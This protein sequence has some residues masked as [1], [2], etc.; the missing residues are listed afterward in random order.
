MLQIITPFNNEELYIKDFLDSIVEG[1]KY[2][3]NFKLFL[4]NDF[5]ED[6]SF[7]IAKSY[8]DEH[9]NIKLINNIIKGK[10][11]AINLGLKNVGESTHLKFCDAD[12]VLTSSFFKSIDSILQYDISVHNL[13]IT[14]VNLNVISPLKVNKNIFLNF[15]YVIENGI[16]IPKA[17]W[18][19]KT[20]F[21]KNN[22]IPDEILFEDFWFTFILKKTNK[23]IFYFNNESFYLYR[24]NNNQTFG[25]VNNNSNEIV[26]WRSKRLIKC[27]NGL[28]NLNLY[29]RKK[30][31]HI[32]LY[33]ELRIKFNL[34]SFL[35][36]L[37][38]NF[39]LAIKYFVYFIFGN[40]IF[41]LKNIIWKLK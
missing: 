25:G 28:I 26:S 34:R 41:Y 3:S 13:E 30:L 29:T 22:L 16:I 35:K 1:F 38:N 33:N 17:C 21:L 18:T 24:Q 40:K 27:Y 4:I 14:S 5:S 9:K 20:E 10:V 23:S 2:N 6:S 32:L 31:N 11:N 39:K 12:D 7:E 37:L 19:F 8:S 36:L 15:N